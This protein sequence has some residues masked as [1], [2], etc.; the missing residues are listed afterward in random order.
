MHGWWVFM[1]C[2]T[3]AGLALASGHCRRRRAERARIDRTRMTVEA[4][5]P[6]VFSRTSAL[7][8]N[9]KQPDDT[10][11]LDPP[12]EDNLSP[13]AS[14]RQ[15]APTGC[16]VRPRRRVVL[17]DPSLSTTLRPGWRLL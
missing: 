1:G 4:W 13:S 6:A 8:L 17:S 5:L 2:L 11:V 16:A 12:T 14:P 10:T 7:E 9:P 15:A 3:A